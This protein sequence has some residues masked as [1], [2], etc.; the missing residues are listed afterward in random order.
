MKKY[1][2]HHTH[3]RLMKKNKEKNTHFQM[4]LIIFDHANT[5]ARMHLLVEIHNICPLPNALA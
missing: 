5:C 3:E 4:F 1:L 2:F